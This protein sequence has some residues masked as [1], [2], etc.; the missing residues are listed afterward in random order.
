MS[1]GLAPS[2]IMLARLA[3]R[4]AARRRCRRYKREGTGVAAG[5]ILSLGHEALVSAR[6]AE[7]RFL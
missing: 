6:Q 1:A 7:V 2:E 5:M 4:R 3:A